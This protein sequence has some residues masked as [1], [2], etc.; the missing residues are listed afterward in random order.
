MEMCVLIINLWLWKVKSFV[1]SIVASLELSIR[2]FISFVSNY[3]HLNVLG[4]TDFI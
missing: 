2:N 3:M 4:F 1:V